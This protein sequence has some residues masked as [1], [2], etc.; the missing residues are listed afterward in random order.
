MSEENE[1]IESQEPPVETTT[2]DTTAETQETLLGAKPAAEEAPAPE[3]FDLEKLELPEG[4]SL[5]DGDKEFL[6]KAAAEHGLT[7]GAVSS[8]LTYYASKMQEFS[9]SAHEA[10]TQTVTE[11]GDKTRAEYGD[12]LNPVLGQIG[13]VLDEFG[14]DELR[15]AFTLTGIGNHPELV[16]F[17]ERVAGALGEGRPVNPAGE[18]G[19]EADPLLKMYPSMKKG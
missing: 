13:K 9:A 17:L 7:Q 16:R 8:L 3:P 2:E 5:E 1:Q 6:T 12:R 11:W 14:S 18:P 10:F 19:G 15:E 4:L